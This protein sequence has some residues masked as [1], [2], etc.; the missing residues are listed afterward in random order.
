ML[1]QM[2]FRMHLQRPYMNDIVGQMQKALFISITTDESTD[3]SVFG[4]LP[5][6]HVQFVDQNFDNSHFL[7]DFNVT[8]EDTYR[9]TETLVKALA[10]ELTFLQKKLFVL[11]RMGHL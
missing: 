2:R 6:L 9:I 7:E 5:I 4:F 11:G 3:I 10:T 8:E 1:L